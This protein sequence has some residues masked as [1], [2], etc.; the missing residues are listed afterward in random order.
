MCT[1][2][3][4][5]LWSV[6]HVR[7]CTVWVYLSYAAINL[8]ECGK[9]A[10]IIFEHEHFI[11]HSNYIACL[12]NLSLIFSKQ[13]TMEN[14][15]LCAWLLIYTRNSIHVIHVCPI[16]FGFKIFRVWWIEI[17]RTPSNNLLPIIS[18]LFFSRFNIYCFFACYVLFKTI[19]N[20]N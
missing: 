2:Y 6:R 7:A 20:C 14:V 4:W 16:N 19:F 13:I 18:F 5:M 3:E 1:V 17:K 9:K 8:Q 11:I 15:L 10:K 12:S